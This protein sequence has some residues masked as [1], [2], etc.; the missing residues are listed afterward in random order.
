M[1]D[2]SERI[3]QLKIDRS[4]PAEAGRSWVLPG[5]VL[6]ILGV[7]VVGW[8]FF[9]PGSAT[10]LVETD[11]ARKPP[12]A[13]A[14]NSVLDASGYVVARRQATVSSKVTGKV[15]EVLVEEGMRVE[16]DQVVARLDDTTQQ[17]QLSL[18]KAQAESAR[19]MLDEIEAQLRNA[20]QERDRFRDLADQRVQPGLSGGHLRSVCR[21]T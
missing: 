12:S 5:A 21:Q 8:L 9:S 11:I 13:A 16:K 10:V 20:R 2:P 14:A 4:T 6:A 7:A 18:A 15:V 19:A 1:A 17:A 3:N